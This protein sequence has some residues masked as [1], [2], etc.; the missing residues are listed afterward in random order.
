MLVEARDAFGGR[1][2]SV[3]VGARSAHGP[4]GDGATPGCADLGPTSFWPEL[5]P[6]LD[7]LVDDLGLARFARG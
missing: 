3:P 1:V 4:D 2:V 7:R 5:P 6:E